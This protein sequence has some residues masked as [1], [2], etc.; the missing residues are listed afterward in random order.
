MGLLGFIVVAV[1]VMAPAVT[2]QQ[3]YTKDNVNC[4]E[5]LSI[6]PEVDTG[7]V[8]RAVRR[9]TSRTHP[10]RCQVTTPRFFFQTPAH[11]RCRQPSA[12]KSSREQTTAK[13][14]WER[15]WRGSRT[16]SG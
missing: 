12:R 5:L 3:W 16:T 14:R 10:D 8:L 13:R 2:A 15:R 6:D 4:Y 11:A 7:E 9:V 1:V